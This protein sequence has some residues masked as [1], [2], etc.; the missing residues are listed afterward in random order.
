MNFC[1]RA[2]HTPCGLFGKVNYFIDK[3]QQSACNFERYFAKIK[4]SGL[5]RIPRA[6]R[7]LFAAELSQNPLRYIADGSQN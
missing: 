5:I 6:L 2:G 7:L 3:K 1:Q 4:D